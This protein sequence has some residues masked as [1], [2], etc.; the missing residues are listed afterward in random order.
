MFQIKVVDLNDI[1]STLYMKFF[2][3]EPPLK[4]STKI[5]YSK[6]YI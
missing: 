3:D 4:I 1:H 5:A 6:I 2:N